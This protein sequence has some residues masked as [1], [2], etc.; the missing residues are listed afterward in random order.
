[1]PRPDVRTVPTT[2]AQTLFAWSAPA[3]PHLTVQREGAAPH[4]AL[5]C[6]S[7]YLRQEL[8][9][10]ATTHNIARCCCCCSAG[11]RYC[12]GYAR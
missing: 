8:G 5:S 10:R 6:T 7:K 12:V 2:T 1:M 9:A 4:H 3:S 11:S